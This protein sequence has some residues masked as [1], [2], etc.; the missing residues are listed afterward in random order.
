MVKSSSSGKRKRDLHGF[1]YGK[2]TFWK[3]F[4]RQNASR[5]CCVADKTFEKLSSFS[6]KNTPTRD[7]K[8]VDNHILQAKFK[9]LDFKKILN[10]ASCGV[11]WSD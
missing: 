4:F 9:K 5:A 1:L 10:H 7:F 6:E 11:S 3:A 8:F 2:N